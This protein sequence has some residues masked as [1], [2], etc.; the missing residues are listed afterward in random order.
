MIRKF[1]GM[2]KAK[3]PE[4]PDMQDFVKDKPWLI[5]PQWDVLHHERS[6]DK[7]LAEESALMATP[8]TTGR[9]GAGA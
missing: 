4:K 5:N 9:T 6:L 1:G 8:T 7:V 3:A 2:I